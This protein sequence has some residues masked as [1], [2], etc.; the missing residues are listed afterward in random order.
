MKTIGN[1]FSGRLTVIA[2]AALL[3][4]AQTVF[5]GDRDLNLCLQT[6]YTV[7]ARIYHTPR[8]TDV[9]L[10]NEYSPLSDIFSYGGELRY[11]IP[12]SMIE[13][14]LASEYLTAKTGG[15]YPVVVGN[16]AFLVPST[17]QFTFVP[18]ELSA[19]MILPFSGERVRISMGGGAG[20]YFGDRTWRI[21]DSQAPEGKTGVSAGL[22]VMTGVDYMITPGLA[23][24]GMLKFRDPQFDTDNRFEHPYIR[25]GNSSL[26]LDQSD[27]IT[28]IN[29]DGIA[30]TLGIVYYF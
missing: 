22:Q 13:I 17:E 12:S 1:S 23:V 24:R 28:R 26:P 7:S 14:S 9:T 2:G 5:A 20:L 15:T 25:Y 4:L 16:Q 29:I 18:V 11:H 6:T 30:F 3:A 27:Y 8:S 19:L 10:R 21:G